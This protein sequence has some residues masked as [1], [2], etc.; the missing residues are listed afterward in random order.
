MTEELEQRQRPSFAKLVGLDRSGPRPER[1][2]QGE[3]LNPWTIPNAIAFV[4][5][6]LIPVFVV[7]A[8]S[9]EEGKTTTAAWL[10]GALAWSDYFDGLIARLTGQFS[11]LGALLDPFSDRLLAGSG[12]LVCY[13]L[14]ILPRWLL[15]VA[16]AR[17]FL[18][19]VISEISLRAKVDI[20]INWPGR[21][22]VWPLFSSVFFA[23]LG[24]QT[25]GTILL[26]VGVA[27]ALIASAIY[28]RNGVREYRGNISPRP[29]S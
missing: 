4:R 27:L 21:L 29:S 6:A 7:V 5:L 18:T 16:V 14:D 26:Y 20:T 11:R 17:E 13:Y 12:Y 25:F 1:T 19:L 24:Y 22:A 9:S 10:Y 3:P 23:L 2:G 8:L 15:I 28:I